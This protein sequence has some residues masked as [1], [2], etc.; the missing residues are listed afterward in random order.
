MKKSIQWLIINI[1]FVINFIS[2][3]E[4]EKKGC[5]ESQHVDIRIKI[6]DEKEDDT[7]DI[8]SKIYLH[9]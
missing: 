2:F 6:I 9:C 5:G 1:K 3:V 4:V 7:V 8:V